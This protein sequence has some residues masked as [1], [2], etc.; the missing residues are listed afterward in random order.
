MNAICIG[1]APIVLDS[2]RFTHGTATLVDD[3]HNGVAE[4]IQG[5]W[6]AQVDLGAGASAMQIAFT[7][8]E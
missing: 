8:F 7:A 1:L 3:D 4:K 2:L 6:D 5:T